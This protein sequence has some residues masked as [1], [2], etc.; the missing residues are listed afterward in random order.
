MYHFIQNLFTNAACTLDQSKFGIPTW[1]KYL[2]GENDPADPS[3]CRL[4]L[5]FDADKIPQ[6]A[7]IGLAVVE[8][9]LVIA[10]MV[11]IGYIVYGGFRYLLSQGEPENTRIAK[12]AILNAVIGLVI[13][14][15]ASI[16]VRF[17]GQEV[18]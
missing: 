6:L 1:Y 4:A 17:V 18:L 9:M 3:V 12:D 15:M 13:A 7:S 8:I 14:V 10:G 11:S 16:I 5:E 2:E